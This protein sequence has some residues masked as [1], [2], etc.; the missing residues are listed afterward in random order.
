MTFISENVIPK[1]TELTDFITA[2]AEPILTTLAE[3]VLPPIKSAFDD[4][5]GAI[6]WVIEKIGEVT[7]GL[8]DMDIPDWLKPGSPPPLYYALMDV[9]KAMG[10]LSKY[11]IPQFNAQM[12]TPFGGAGAGRTVTNYTSVSPQLTI[13]PNTFNNGM[14]LAIVEAVAERVLTNALAGV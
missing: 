5:A 11:S 14:D 12:A 6:D 8:Q 3:T 13:G 4:I 7:S 9:G 1:W 2:T 10:E